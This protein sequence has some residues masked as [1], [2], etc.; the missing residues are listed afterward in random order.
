MTRGLSI[1]AI[2][3]SFAGALCGQTFNGVQNQALTQLTQVVSNGTTA[4]D[5]A[6]LGAELTSSSGWTSTGWTG[7]YNAWAHSASNAN[8][9][10][11]TLTITSGS[12]Y[13]VVITLSSVTGGSVTATLGGA[14]INNANGMGSNA[15]FTS[16]VK[17]TS[18]AGLIITPIS[19]FVGTVAV[20]VKL[21]TPISTYAFLG[22][23]STGA[24]SYVAL[25]TLASLLNIYEGGGGAF[26]TTGTQDSAQG[27]YALYSNTTGTQDSA[28]GSYALYS[29][30]T[31][32]DNSAQGSYALYSNTTGNNN[33]GVGPYA[34]Y[35]NTTGSNNSAQGLGALQNNTTANANLAI[36]ASALYSNTT[37][38]SNMAMGY[39]AGYGTSFTNANTTGS[40]NS[41]FGY[42]AAPGSATQQNYMTVIG[43]TATGTCSN[44][45]VLGRPG[46]IT[47]VSG[48]TGNGASPTIANGTGTM[49]VNV[50]STNL[51]GT[52]TSS[53]SGTVTFTMTWANSMAYPHRAVCSFIDE[54]TNADSIRATQATPATTTTLTATG[55][56]VTGDIVSY[57]C[58]GS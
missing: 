3:V 27:S 43:A 38:A 14:D 51:A 18:T 34:L 35:S 26:N 45:V 57:Q 33:L 30:T 37:G 10:S 41:F 2:A 53:T 32:I 36:G 49:A 58:S 19:T 50:G 28:Q 4:T 44:C 15:A 31:G 22:K 39:Q 17:A 25:Q 55:T 12:F 5:S 46:D 56:T 1:L 54:T 29:N 52:L 8:P 24:T 20:S 9:L 23:D 16:G 40:D 42:E 47:Y 48:E 11:E 7:S 6:S 21:I 13:Q